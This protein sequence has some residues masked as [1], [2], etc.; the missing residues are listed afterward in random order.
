MEEEAVCEDKEREGSEDALL[1]VA[2]DCEAEHRCDHAD[3]WSEQR[4][5]DPDVGAGLLLARR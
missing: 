1:Q 3:V 5:C 4:N 2:L